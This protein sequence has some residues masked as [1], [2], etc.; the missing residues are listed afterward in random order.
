M[1]GNLTREMKPGQPASTDVLWGNSG[2]VVTG[3]DG[4]ADKLIS[5][6][7]ADP[8]HAGQC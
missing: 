3:Q 6:G 1:I 7:K 5:L 4:G 2:G 8:R